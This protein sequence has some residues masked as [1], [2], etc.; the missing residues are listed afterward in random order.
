VETGFPPSRSPLRR[1]KEGPKRSCSKKVYRDG[2]FCAHRVWH[3]NWFVEQ[4]SWHDVEVLASPPPVTGTT[5][6]L[7]QLAAVEL[8]NIMQ[9]V[10]AD[11]TVVVS[12]VIAVVPCANAAP[13]VQIADDSAADIAIT[14][15]PR[16]I[17]ASR[18]TS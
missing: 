4:A 6:L 16:R 14:I 12:G 3:D 18:M 13:A 10:T 9:V 8:H 11:V 5:Q 7:W 15:A 17:I 2:E 1:A